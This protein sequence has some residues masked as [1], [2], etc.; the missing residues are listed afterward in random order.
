MVE[1]RSEKY[2]RKCTQ[3]PELGFTASTGQIIKCTDVVGPFP[4][5]RIKIRKVVRTRQ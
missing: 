2:P 5:A 3:K 4:D 1:K